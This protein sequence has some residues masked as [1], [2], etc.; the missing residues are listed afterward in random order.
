MQP[1]RGGLFDGM[2][3]EGAALALGDVT[4]LAPVPRPAKI[5]A[6]AVN[7]P[8]H[9]PSGASVLKEDGP[10]KEPQLFLKPSSSI[11]GPN[12]TIVLPE[13]A[14][15][16][17]AEGELVAVMGRECRNVTAA[18]ALEYVLRVHL[19]ERRQ[20]AALAAGRRAVVAGEGL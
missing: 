14:R 17:D 19:R 6:A 1:V 3:A 11:A 8:S 7:Y 20:R 16:V 15:R 18:E 4:L 9:V 10:P 12:D 2:E 5:L 13:G